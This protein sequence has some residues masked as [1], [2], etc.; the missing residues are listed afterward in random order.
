M[1]RKE[2]F[3]VV[4]AGVSSY[5]ICSI[6]TWIK[7][8]GIQIINRADDWS[9]R[10]HKTMG[11]VDVFRF[12]GKLQHIDVFGADAF[13]FWIGIGTSVIAAVTM[14]LIYVIQKDSKPQTEKTER[15]YKVKIKKP[16][17]N[18]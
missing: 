16:T 6:I 9:L 10:L 1:N 5:V 7:E 3:G 17:A 8:G 2:K 13:L 4:K 11:L 18:T 12:E 14:K 15:G